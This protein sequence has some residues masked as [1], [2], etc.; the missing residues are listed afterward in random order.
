[1]FLSPVVEK[2][3][4][5]L[6]A[7][8]RENCYPQSV[9]PNGTLFQFSAMEKCSF[10][11]RLMGAIHSIPVTA[12]LSA[13]SE[14]TVVETGRVISCPKDVGRAWVSSLT[15]ITFE[16]D[17]SGEWFAGIVALKFSSFRVRFDTCQLIPQMLFWAG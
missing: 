3:G 4:N 1:M 10:P 14:Q 9:G 15:S 13:I 16:S 17:I 5:H 8:K 11:L 7:S 12:I 6:M 2:D